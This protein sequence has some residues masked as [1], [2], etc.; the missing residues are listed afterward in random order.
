[1]VRPL[2][3]QK[4]TSTTTPTA[5]TKRQHEKK[6][7]YINKILYHTKSVRFTASSCGAA[8][9]DLIH[10]L[11]FFFYYSYIVVT[12]CAILFS[13]RIGSCRRQ[14]F[15]NETAAVNRMS[16]D[17]L[18]KEYPWINLDFFQQIFD[19]KL[20]CNQSI[21]VCDFSIALALQPGENYGSQIVRAHVKY[22]HGDDV[23]ITNAGSVSAHKSVSLIMKASLGSRVV[24]SCNVFEKEIFMFEEIIPKVENL[25]RNFGIVT[26]MA[27]A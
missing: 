25:L 5:T 3:T 20:F 4:K 22:V 23:I 16:D 21:R 24:R 26:K 9:I 19:Q 17:I 27:P 12:G 10:S 6:G 2:T 7:L 8:S 13:L 18:I 1:M 15:V 11:V 14:C